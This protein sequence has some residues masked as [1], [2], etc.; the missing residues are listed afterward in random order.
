MKSSAAYEINEENTFKTLES[1]ALLYRD[2]L[3][4]Q[5]VLRVA[6]DDLQVNGLQVLPWH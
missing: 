2:L 3:P 6:S 4:L 1:A 5:S